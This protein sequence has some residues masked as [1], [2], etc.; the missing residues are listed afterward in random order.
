MKGKRPRRSNRPAKGPGPGPEG[1]KE[2]G[3]SSDQVNRRRE[4]N[5]RLIMRAHWAQCKTPA[6]AI[7]WS[8]GADRSPRGQPAAEEVVEIRRVDGGGRAFLRIESQD[9][10]P[11]RGP[12]TLW[13]HA[14]RQGPSRRVLAGRWRPSVM[15][16]SQAWHVTS[17]G[18]WRRDGGARRAPS[19]G[20]PWGY[21][22]SWRGGPVFRVTPDQSIGATLIPTRNFPLMY[23]VISPALS[24]SRP[25]ISIG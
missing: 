6:T 9:P 19:W 21:R 15:R 17:L 10:G 3:A 12:G 13:R 20:P 11:S 22:R 2:T 4:A 8:R 5:G 23:R 16:W 24:S 18:G 7:L 1:P 14:H 25:S